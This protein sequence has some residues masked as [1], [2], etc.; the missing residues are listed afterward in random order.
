MSTKKINTCV[1]YI[2]YERIKKYS[3][4]FS[5]Y[6]EKNDINYVYVSKNLSKSDNGNPLC[7]GICINNVK[8]NEVATIVQTGIAKVRYFGNDIENGNSKNIYLAKKYNERNLDGYVTILNREVTPYTYGGAFLIKIGT[9]IP[10]KSK[11]TNKIKTS[12]VNVLLD[13]N[14]EN[15]DL[16]NVYLLS[17]LSKNKLDNKEFSFYDIGSDLQTGL[18]NTMVID[19]FKKLKD[20]YA[21]NQDVD[22]IC[23]SLDQYCKELYKQIPFPKFS[24]Y[25]KRVTAI[26]SSGQCIFDSDYS[27]LGIFDY[28]TN[29]AYKIQLNPNPFN[30]TNFLLFAT[31]INSPLLAYV[32]PNDSNSIDLLGSTF[33]Y[34]MGSIYEFIQASINGV[35][36]SGRYALSNNVYIYNVTLFVGLTDSFNINNGDSIILRL[37]WKKIQ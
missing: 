15:Y 9:V 4:V 8:K 5:F 22:I 16:Y 3:A 28:K 18:N 21:T 36:I 20:A 14:N 2:A 10:K 32:N 23:Y 12:I 35:G 19:K 13:I 33:T 7:V 37:S 34:P 30:K 26:N 11:V 31:L 1:K 6:D 17:S 25:T 24:G 27:K 29:S